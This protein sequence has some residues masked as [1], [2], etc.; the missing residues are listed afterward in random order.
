VTRLR[1]GR[2]QF[3]S[4]EGRRF[5]FSSPPLR[6]GSHPAPYPR[7]TRALSPGTKRPGRESYHSPPSS[8]EVKN[9]WSYTF[10][11]PH[12]FMAWCLVKHMDKLTCIPFLTQKYCDSPFNC[13][14]L[15][16]MW[17]VGRDTAATHWLVHRCQVS[18]RSSLLN[19]IPKPRRYNTKAV[20]SV[21]F[22]RSV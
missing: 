11:P 1:I 5:L 14:L 22:R 13:S 18:P 16:V 15:W 4:R 10:T 19:T 21:L 9:T 7:S 20:I 17:R 6:S 3:D 12:V 8:V 2:S